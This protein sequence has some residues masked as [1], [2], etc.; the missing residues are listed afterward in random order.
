MCLRG[1]RLK[2]RDWLVDADALYALTIVDNGR[3][4]RE[5]AG[6][7]DGIGLDRKHLRLDEASKRYFV[8]G[9]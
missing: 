5:T 7:T 9:Q 4:G 6:S 1:K 3:L 8:G 2:K